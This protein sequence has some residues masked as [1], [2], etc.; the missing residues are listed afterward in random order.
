M[1]LPLYCLTN[2]REV[3]W[4]HLASLTLRGFVAGE[5]ILQRLFNLASLKSIGIAR[6]VLDDDH[7]GFWVRL[8]TALRKKRC[9]EV[10]ISGWLANSRTDED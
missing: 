4:P 10:H 9:E 7:D 6:I 2:E 8:M 5:R 3:D 1:N